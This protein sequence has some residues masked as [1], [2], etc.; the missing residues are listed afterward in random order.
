MATITAQAIGDTGLTPTFT[1]V[2]ASDVLTNDG[3]S[4][5]RVKNGNGANCTVTIAATRECNQGFTHNMVAVVPLTTG[6]MTIGPF[7]KHRFGAAPVATYSVTASV[8]AALIS[9]TPT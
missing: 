2:N 8:T 5:L 4:F 7:P 1:A 9:N 3:N 6:D